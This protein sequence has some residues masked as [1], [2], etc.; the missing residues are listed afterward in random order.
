[1]PIRDWL[2]VKGHLR[3]RTGEIYS[4]DVVFP[5]SYK[6]ARFMWNRACDKA[7]CDEKDS[8]TGRRIYH[9]HCLRKFFRSNVGLDLDVVHALMGHV[10]YLDDTYLRL[11]ERREVA[12][13]Y[14]ACM[15]NVSVY[16]LVDSE[17]RE[18]TKTIVEENV[19]IKQELEGQRVQAETMSKKVVELERKLKVL[20]SPE[21]RRLLKQLEEG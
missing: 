1:M 14:L 2:R 11:E 8:L 9:I 5:F 15:P 4:G 10:E 12:R 6:T 20:D 19:A 13:Q 3:K 21:L 16:D 17:L 18:K 7:G